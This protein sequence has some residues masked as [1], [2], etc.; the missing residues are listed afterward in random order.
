MAKLIALWTRDDRAISVIKPSEW[1][2]I[3][4]VSLMH[5]VKFGEYGTREGTEVSN[6]QHD[7]QMLALAYAMGIMENDQDYTDWKRTY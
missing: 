3:H 1:S 6:T 2:D 5:D 7:T 4:R